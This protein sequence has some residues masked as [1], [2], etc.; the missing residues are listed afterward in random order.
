MSQLYGQLDLTL[1]IFVSRNFDMNQERREK[2]SDGWQKVTC[3]PLLSLLWAA[4]A[5]ELKALLTDKPPSR[6]ASACPCFSTSTGVGAA[7]MSGSGVSL[8][9]SVILF[10]QLGLYA[11]YASIV[12]SSATFPYCCPGTV[13]EWNPGHTHILPPV[14]RLRF[15]LCHCPHPPGYD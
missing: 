2:A 14:S 5:E 8:T 4:G 11:A 10:N 3:R 13:L 12:G 6:M 15:N 1:G 7:D 9:V